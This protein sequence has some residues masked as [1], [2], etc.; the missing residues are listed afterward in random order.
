[1]SQETGA[2]SVLVDLN[3]KRSIRVLHVDDEVSLLK[4]A[5]QCL[6]MEGPFEV[7][8]ATSVDE[9]IQ[10]TNSNTYDVVVSDYQMPSK[11][12]LEFLKELRGQGK[13]VPFIVFT[14]KGREEVAIRA[15]NLGANQYLNKTGDPETV[16]K[17]L[18]HSI[19]EMAR[20]GR[21]E[22]QLKLAYQKLQLFRAAAKASSDGFVL[23]D[24]EGKIIELNDA[25]LRLYGAGKKDEMIGMNSLDL[26]PQEK[27]QKV[28]ANM[29]EV[30]SEGSSRGKEMSFVTR[31]GAKITV[32]FSTTLVKDTAGRPAGFLGIIRDVTKRKEAEEALK[33]SEERYRNLFE[34]SK[35]LKVMFDLKGNITAVNK[36]AL[37][38]GFRANEGVGE[39]ILKYVPE[40]MHLQMQK[41]VEEVLR[42]RTIEGE[43]EIDTPK[44][45]RTFEH[46]SSPI[47]KKGEIVGIS[48]S[49]KDITDRKKAEE[50]SRESEERYSRLSAA[51]FE[52]IGISEQG[53]VVDA[54]DQ[55]ARMLRYQQNEL[56]G[57]A[58]MDF[59]AP[60]SRDLVMDSMRKGSEG[61]YEHL[62]LRKDGSV[63]PV[64]IR[65]RAIPFKGRVARVSAIH[66]ITERKR[67]EEA[68]RK[69][70]NELKA[71]F[72]GSPDLIMI[73]DR[74]HR[75]VR[76]NRTHFLSYDVENL[77][78]KDAIEPLPSDQRELA[79]SNVE[80]C[81][82]TG[83]IQEFEHYLSNGERIRARVVPLKSETTVDRVMIISA[84]I[85]EQTKTEQELRRFSSAV[86]ASLDGVIS[87]D[88]DGK[89][90]Y[91]NGAALSMFGSCDVSDLVGRT[92]QELLVERD[93]GRALQ[94]AMEILQTKR[95]KTVDYTALSKDGS[96][97]PIEVTTQLIENEKGKPIGFV[98]I[99]RDLRERM[100]ERKEAVESKDKFKALFT[101]NPEAAVYWDADYRFLDINPR[102]SELFGYSLEEIKGKET[103]GIIVP[104]DKTEE[105]NVLAK[106]SSEGYI[107]FET[108]RMRKDGSLIPVSI[109]VSPIFDE[110]RLIGYMGLYKDI[111]EKKR[112]EE[113]LSALDTYGQKLNMAES[114]EEIYRLALD[115][116]QKVLGF[117]YADFF[118][119]DKDILRIVDQRGYP[120]PFPL[121]LPLDGS[122]KG[123]S[124]RAVRTGN[125][126]IAKDVRNDT[127]FVQGLPD[128][129]S[130]LIVPIKA[131]GKIFG[132]LNVE[133]KELNAFDKKDQELLEI[134]ASHAVTA[135]INVDRA[136][137]LEAS[138]RQLRESQQMF[139][140]LFADNPEA[141]VRVGPDFCILDANSRFEMLFGY[142]LDEIKGR[143]IN[144]VVVPKDKA[145]EANALDCTA[146]RD[147]H[148]SKDTIRQRKD[149]SLVPV[150]VSAAPISV[151]GRFLGYVAVYKDISELKKTEHEMA[152]MN[153][154]LRVVG[155]LTRHDVRNK[156]ST[157]TGNLYLLGKQLAGDI[158]AVDKLK[159]MQSA[160]Q[161]TVRILEFA[162]TYEMLG[163]EELVYVDIEK[164]INEAFSFFPSLK[165]IK[166]TSECHGFCV[167]ADSLLRQL[168]YNLVDNSL[169]YGQK[170][171]EIKVHCEKKTDKQLELVYEDDGTGISEQVKQRLFT[172][173]FTTGKGTGYGLYLVKKMMEV[174]GWTIQETGEPG[175]GVRFV[176]TIPKTNPIGKECYRTS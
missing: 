88:L 42:G 174:Y 37:Q 62:A 67:T 124:I 26:V 95:G 66:D 139:E 171:T 18:A 165:D 49:Y 92:V 38:Y 133:S 126:V 103:F 75:Y 51:A 81:F 142:K 61:P 150:F 59:V 11:D 166:V 110:N 15:L 157:I 77:I 47:L 145:D 106:K 91:V 84:D 98:D 44:G 115:A 122:K 167:L 63:F 56:I 9:A 16:Y 6:E 152:I 135:I 45:K 17:E 22:E 141:A 117:K 41:N 93:R 173:G 136:M 129:L 80:K 90:T 161:Q 32:D 113:R 83:E 109:S 143:N 172:E 57:K 50:K 12:G 119:I 128:T 48:G 100:L 5:K 121:E 112:F 97:I 65:A 58:V 101:G 175:K 60:E 164:T 123:L 94:N 89:I 86:K 79:R 120:E 35:D 52:G 137:A 78:G 24:L 160:V 43:I 2:Y 148:V 53:R 4:I 34:N 144:D 132:A 104:K 74:E 125:S 40:T 130:E 153:E 21:T 68:L 70:E 54:N 8:T 1:M 10:K 99:I 118:M 23:T 105:S 107:N 111:T 158:N 71:Q 102:F 156:L 7:D 36:V 72:Y 149:G 73:L 138:A 25:I 20:I 131:G 168:F 33:V 147:K 87:G 169:K 19:T 127:E 76:I 155:G 31:E 116:M 176:I 55:L 64:E 3:E 108:V 151:E 46:I 82:A 114:K 29:R 14:G 13:N 154:K 28:A 85:T 163:A 30:I 162:K 69:S 140:R 39:S 134:L 170:L 146:E 159:D 27:R 96:E